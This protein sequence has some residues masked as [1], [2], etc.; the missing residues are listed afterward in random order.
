[1]QNMQRGFSLVIIFFCSGSHSKGWMGKVL[2]CIK[3]KE[4]EWAVWRWHK[5]CRERT[6]NVNAF[7][8][9][10]TILIRPH[11]LLLTVSVNRFPCS[12]IPWTYLQPMIALKGFLCPCV[13]WAGVQLLLIPPSLCCFCSSFHFSGHVWIPTGVGLVLEVLRDFMWRTSHEPFPVLKGEEMQMEVFSFFLSYIFIL[14]RPKVL[15]Y[16]SWSRAAHSAYIIS[17]LRSSTCLVWLL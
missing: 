2:N 3:E 17:E 7:C 6:I 4:T 13:I 16:S 12:P 10:S 5:S 11:L 14:N 9:T 1:M 15:I 8:V